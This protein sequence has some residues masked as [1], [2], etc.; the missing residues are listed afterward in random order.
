ML[1]LKCRVLLLS[2]PVCI[3]LWPAVADYLFSVQILVCRLVHS[4]VHSP[5]HS[6]VHGPVYSPADLESTFYRV[7]VDCRP[8]TGCDVNSRECNNTGDSQPYSQAPLPSLISRLDFPALFPGS[9]PQPH[10]QARLPSLIPR[11]HSPASFPGS[12]PQLHSQAPLPSFI[13]RLHSPASFP[14]ST[15]QLFIA[16]CNKKLG[17]GAWE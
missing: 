10:F 3:S 13:P 2:H 1:C 5:V 9:T 6:P 15:P 7:R 12:T 11:L 17:S 4:A 14:G 8:Q 16:Q